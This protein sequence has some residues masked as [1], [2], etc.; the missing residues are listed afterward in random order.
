VTVL[1]LE[2]TEQA[3]TKDEQNVLSS[4]NFRV[5]RTQISCKHNNQLF[6]CVH[7]DMLCTNSS[8]E[9][10]RNAYV[11]QDPYIKL[12]LQSNKGKKGESA[13]TKTKDNAGSNATFNEEILL[14]KKEDEVPRINF[15]YVCVRWT[16]KNTIARIFSS[17]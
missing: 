13:K 12:T 5:S 2:S 15:S 4:Q 1:P 8:S 17:C 7:N 6:V 3:P 11:H 10:H 14:N 16:L 9:P